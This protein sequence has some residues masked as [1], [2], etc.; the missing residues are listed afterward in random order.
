MLMAKPPHFRRHFTSRKRFKFAT[1]HETN[2][3][4]HFM[5]AIVRAIDV[6]YGNTKYTYADAKGEIQCGIFPSLTQWNAKDPSKGFIGERR[7]TAVVTVDHMYHE[8]GPDVGAA[9]GRYHASNMHDG[10][11]DTPQYKALVKGALHYMND[12]RID[13]LVMGLPVRHLIAKRAMLEKAWQG[14][15][16]IATGRRV[17]IDKVR[18]FAQP[19]GALAYY[20]VTTRSSG[21]TKHDL[22][23]VIDPGQR[24]FDW[25]M[26][27]GMT[28]VQG[29]SSSTDRGM[30]DIVKTIAQMISVDLDEQYQDYEAIDA[31]IRSNKPLILYQQPYDIR[32][33]KPV[34]EQVT[35]EA[36]ARLLESVR[37]LA[38]IQ[39][40]LLVGG[41]ASVFRPAV[42]A[43]FKKH[44]IT[45]I[46]EPVF[47]NVRGF[48][49]IGNEIL[50]RQR[51]AAQETQRVQEGRPS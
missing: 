4:E 10:Y 2:G 15:H 37:D 25:L 49:T 38:S 13:L 29:Q 16:E 17:V 50:V 26:S 8:V 14:E 39:N 40:I 43:A 30:F 51:P 11:I 27:R 46:D 9:R 18:V 23:L 3:P 7:N 36:V 35:R 34:I 48:Q 6:G 33:F 24:T 20:S 22:N 21:V 32:R 12:D 42:K 41:G 44:A 28:L 19:Q 5:P 1:V 31:S 47:A 45:D